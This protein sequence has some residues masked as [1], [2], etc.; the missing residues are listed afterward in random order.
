VRAIL[1]VLTAV[2]ILAVGFIGWYRWDTSRNRGHSW[3][4]WGEFN[5]VS[6][7]LAQ[8]PGVTIVKAYCNQD[9]SLEEFGFEIRTSQKQEIKLF[10]SE[11]DPTRSLSGNK[12]RAALV[13]QIQKE[14]SGR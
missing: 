13:K 10:F 1:L 6:N 7:T 3:G 12:L 4:Y 8:L 2:C 11:N 5:T 14:S 9:V